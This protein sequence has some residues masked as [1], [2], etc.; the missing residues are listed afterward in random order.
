SDFRRAIE[1]PDASLEAWAHCSLLCQQRKDSEGGRKAIAGMLQKF[2]AS[3]NSLQANGLAWA[4]ALSPG[5]ISD[6][7]QPL[8]LAEK[9]V[10]ESRNAATLNTLG[11]VEC[12]AKRPDDAIKHLQDAIK[13][14][15]G[16][17]TAWDWLFLA[18]AHH[19][20]GNADKAR[21]WFDKAAAG[22]DEA[23]DEDAG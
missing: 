9:A 3:A 20:L 7:K 15:G 21:R 22:I 2:S 18:M 4:C 19:Q 10:A 6:W 13:L 8:E 17:G 23:S 11:A 1:L 14:Q 16:G 5:S 12:R